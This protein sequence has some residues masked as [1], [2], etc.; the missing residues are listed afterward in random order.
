MGISISK[1]SNMKFLAL[2]VLVAAVSAKDIRIQFQAPPTE[3]EYGYCEGSPEP[4]SLDVITVAPFPI[5]IQNG[6]EITLQV[7]VTLNEE[8]AVGAKVHLDL[9]LEGLIPIPIPCLEINGLHLGSCDYDGDELLGTV[10]DFLC[11]DYVPE[12]QTCAL[13]LGPGVYGGG[14]PLV[15][16]PIEDIPDILLPFLKGT[17]YAEAHLT[18]AGGDELACLWVR[19]AVDH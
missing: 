5:I 13:P 18:S 16:G 7:Q 17:I 1:Y 8:I 15:I 2:I 19:A 4:V 11:P 3:L 12:G 9:K 10:G 14:E 6:A